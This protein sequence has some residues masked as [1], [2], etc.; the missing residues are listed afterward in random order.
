MV[1]S[2]RA[3]PAESAK[4]G[5]HVLMETEA[6]STEPAWVCTRSSLYALWLLAWCSCGLL[7]VGADVSLI[8]LAV[9]G[10]LFL[11]LRCLALP[12]YEDFALS[13]YVLFC[14]VLLLSLR[15]LLSSE[16]ETEGE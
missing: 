8:S 3:C 7:T 9:L 16:E 14:P 13:Y 6:A 15:R 10:S 1:D 11:L 2:R 12:L 5:T 4:W